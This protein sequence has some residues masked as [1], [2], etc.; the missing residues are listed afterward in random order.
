MTSS[1]MA[2]RRHY[3]YWGLEGQKNGAIKLPKRDSKSKEKYLKRP[4]SEK[5]LCVQKT[6]TKKSNVF[7]HLIYV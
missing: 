1:T 2:S 5:N 6:W 4:Q 3:L 7:D